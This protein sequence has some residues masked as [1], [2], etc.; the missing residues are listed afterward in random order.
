MEVAMIEAVLNRGKDGCNE[1]YEYGNS[2]IWRGM[3]SA[4]KR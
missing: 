1:V 2:R 3:R 4:K